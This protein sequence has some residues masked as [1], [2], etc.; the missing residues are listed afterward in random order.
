MGKNSDSYIATTEPQI[1]HWLIQ[2][3]KR[4]Q[5]APAPASTAQ[6]VTHQES[7]AADVE[8]DAGM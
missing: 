7:F 6:Q 2:A 3:N 1:S 8:I 4:L 5:S